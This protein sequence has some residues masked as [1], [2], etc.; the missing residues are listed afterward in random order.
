VGMSSPPDDTKGHAAKGD[1]PTLKNHTLLNQGAFQ[2][3]YS[4]THQNCIW[5]LM[6]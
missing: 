1:T 6:A 3:M 2:Y 4:F 5:Q